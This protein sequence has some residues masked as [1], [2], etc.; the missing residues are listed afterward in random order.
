VERRRPS[1]PPHFLASVDALKHE[2]TSAATAITLPVSASSTTHKL[3][4][5]VKQRAASMRRRAAPRNSSADASDDKEEKDGEEELAHRTP[6]P[7]YDPELDEKDAAWVQERIGAYRGDSS[8][9]ELATVLT[10]PACFTTLCFDCQRHDVYKNQYRAMFVENCTVTHTRVS[11]NETFA[12]ATRPNPSSR[13]NRRLPA[14][15]Q[16]TAK[17]VEQPPISSSANSQKIAADVIRVETEQPH[18][19]SVF[20]P[21]ACSECNTV[22]A[23]LDSDEVYHF[24]NVLASSQ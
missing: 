22:V 20:H 9:D 13:R 10:C 8:K 1:R 7:L 14:N 17:S 21:V 18:D 4:P 11:P 3:R 2:P 15:A 12:S 23:A 24:F 19:N 16:P 5:E 6:D